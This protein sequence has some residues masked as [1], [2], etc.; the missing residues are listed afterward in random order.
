MPCAR[1]VGQGHAE[2]SERIGA[3]LLA[4]MDG[5]RKDGQRKSRTEGRQRTARPPRSAEDEGKS[6][7]GEKS[8][9]PSQEER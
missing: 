6:Q 9:N 3:Q 5:Q 7:E 8:R 4:L 2:E 1:D